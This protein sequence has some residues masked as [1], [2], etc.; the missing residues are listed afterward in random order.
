MGVSNAVVP[1]QDSNLRPVNRKSNAL[2]IAQCV[3][4]LRQTHVHNLSRAN[5]S[6]K[7]NNYTYLKFD[8]SFIQQRSPIGRLH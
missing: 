2:T 1:S 4:A 8:V 3:A 6:A 5:T 7:P